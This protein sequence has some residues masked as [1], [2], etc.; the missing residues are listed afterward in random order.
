MCRL[1]SIFQ[2]LR[3]FCLYLFDALFNLITDPSMVDIM[4]KI[5][6]RVTSTWAELPHFPDLA[7]KLVG[8]KAFLVV[9]AGGFFNDFS[10]CA[11]YSLEDTGKVDLIYDLFLRICYLAFLS[12][13]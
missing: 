11:S 8:T 6:F 4:P 9:A 1:S 10:Y 13:R 12:L 3:H 2:I 7:F 5:L